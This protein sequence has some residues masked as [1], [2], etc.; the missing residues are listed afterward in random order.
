MRNMELMVLI[1]RE[2]SF[3]IMQRCLLVHVAE[4]KHIRVIEPEESTKC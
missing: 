2:L 3:T 1:T 4:A